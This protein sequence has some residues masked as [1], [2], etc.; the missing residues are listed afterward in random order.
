MTLCARVSNADV[1]QYAFP[2]AQDVRTLLGKCG[3]V[4][5]CRIQEGE[6]WVR[7]GRRVILA[8][9]GE[10]PEN[11]PAIGLMYATLIKVGG[12]WIIQPD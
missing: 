8:Y 4:P 3:F 12:G 5:L 10:R 2:A 9:K 6:H 1:V 11:V 7:R